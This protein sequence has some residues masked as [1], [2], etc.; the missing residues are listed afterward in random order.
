[1]SPYPRKAQLL[2]LLSVS[3]STEG[4]E[5]IKVIKMPLEEIK[6]K[7][8]LK[9]VQVIKAIEMLSKEIRVIKMSLKMFQTPRRIMITRPSKAPQRLPQPQ[10]L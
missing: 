9:A 4:L 10:L 5:A 7:M 3:F 6:I 2:L 1:M 8:S